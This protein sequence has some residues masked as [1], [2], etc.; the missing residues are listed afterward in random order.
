MICIDILHDIGS[1]PAWTPPVTDLPMKADSE[2]VFRDINAA[3]YAPYPM[4]PTFRSL[5]AMQPSYDLRGVDVVGCGSTIGNLLRFARS[6]RKTFR[7]D[8]DVIGDTVVFVRK[9]STPTELITDLQGYGH[10]FPE[11]YTTWDSEVR[12]SCSHQRIIKYEFGGLNF[13]VRTETDGYVKE[14][15]AKALLGVANPT[16]R[17]PLEDALGKMAVSSIEVLQ[18]HQ[19]QWKIQGTR[20]RQDQIFDIKTRA[21]Y[22]T[23][24]MNEFLPRLWVNQ[25]PR[26]LIAYHQSGLFDKP[27]VK[28]VRQEVIR[29]EKDNPALLA[30]FHAVVKRIVDVVRDSDQRQ[31]EVSWDGQGALYITKQIGEVRRALPPDLFH[32]L[33]AS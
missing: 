22:K 26:L 31:C 29:W 3:R 30:R 17:L 33:E 4:E 1:P 18:D 19:L 20:V 6:E 32:L 11:A 15:D 9:E 27:K 10:T 24:D 7:F 2:D 8:V 28:D 12:N 14:T 16:S 25:T 5:Q 21:S 23:A 13:L